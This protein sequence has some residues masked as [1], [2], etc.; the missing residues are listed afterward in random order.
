MS[1]KRNA[2]RKHTHWPQGDVMIHCS[3][4][5]GG[6]ESMENKN[7]VAKIKNLN[8][9]FENKIEEIF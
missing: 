8:Q 2:G 3:P 7:M 6:E 5:L 1:G 4:A 9:S